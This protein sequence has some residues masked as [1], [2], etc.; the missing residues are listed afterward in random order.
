MNVQITDFS[1]TFLV[2][3]VWPSSF[4]KLTASTRSLR[5]FDTLLKWLSIWTGYFRAASQLPLP[6]SGIYSGVLL[7][8]FYIYF[9]FTKLN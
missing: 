4:P 1:L 3:S 8:F 6:L 9:V 5:L 7:P 2:L